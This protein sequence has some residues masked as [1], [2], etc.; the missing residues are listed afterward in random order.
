MLSRISNGDSPHNYIALA[1]IPP[2]ASMPVDLTQIAIAQNNDPDI[3]DIF[4][5]IRNQ[6]QPPDMSRVNHVIE[7]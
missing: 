1:Q 4:S 6:P 7:N 5:A 2:S 3:Q